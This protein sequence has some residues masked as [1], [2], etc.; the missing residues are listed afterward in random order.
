[1]Y[2]YFFIAK[3]NMRKQRKDM[4]TFFILTCLSSLLIFISSSLLYG[5]PRVIDT[6]HD[7][8]NGADIMILLSDHTPAVTKLSEIIEG[9]IYIDRYEMTDC[10]STYCK[11]RHKGEKEWVEYSFTICA[12]DEKRTIEKTSIDISGLK[13]NEA[14][15]PVSLSTEFSEGS[16]IQLKIG[17]NIYDMKVKG[18]NEDMFYCS[19]VNLGS[20][21][22]FV[23]RGLYND[24]IFE[25]SSSVAQQNKRFALKITNTARKRNMDV[26]EI[27]DMMMNEFVDWDLK[28][29]ASHPEYPGTSFN[30]L[31]APL[32]KTATMIMP[33]I[34]VAIVLLFA[35]II[36]IIAVVII[37]FS[38]KNFIMTNMKNTA[39]MEASGYTVN[40]LVLILLTQLLLI[41][42]IG[43]V[44]GVLTGAALIG[45]IGVIQL[46]LMGLSWNQPVFWGIAAIVVIGI[47]LIITGI[48]FLLGMDYKK[49]S[50]LE[51]LRGGI[52]AHNFKKNHFPF[53]TTG[54]P[55]PL[56]MALKETFGRFSSKIGIIFIAAVLTVSTT[57]GFGL[58]DT[59]FYDD[60]AVMNMGGFIAEDAEVSGDETMYNNL[61]T[62]SSVK[63]VYGDNHMAYEYTRGKSRQSITTRCFTDMENIHGGGLVEGRWPKHDNEVVLATNAAGRLHAEVGDV[64]MIKSGEKEDSYIVCGL[65]QTFNNMGM[66]GFMTEG[67]QERIS[68]K[69]H[70]KTWSIKLKDGFSFKTF[71]SEFKDIYPD[72]DIVNVEEATKST[73]GTIKG[74]MKG[75][76][77]GIAVLT[78]LITAFVEA[79]V[80]RTQINREWRDLGVSKALGFTSSQ[81]IL[82]TTVSNLPGVVIGLILGLMASTASGTKLSI[83]IFGI[84]G[85]KRVD[86]SINPASYLLTF[87]IICGS[88]VITS[89]FTGRRIRGL[90]PVRMITEE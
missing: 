76:S 64:V 2:R 35:L 18:F 58:I 27:S 12:S 11:Y 66:M 61:M 44:S 78:I 22:T 47:C 87:I 89:A 19:S 17:D 83:M 70:E 74:A 39:I 88:A 82:Q 36:F 65:N 68:P 85:F 50:V 40:E 84:F 63:Y 56:T 41:A 20:Y 62:M 54:L 30:F 77:M 60:E 72:V 55:V 73:I 59:F 53:D 26:N 57:T 15:L 43:S 3:N 24:L 46:F 67:G 5:T 71:E 4:F 31:P 79:L 90:D 28:Y 51:A 45:R 69:F 75:I 80:I 42:V 49:T 52:N 86:F 29:V 37:D 38:V 1:M 9:N 16:I 10:I 48:T 6:N 81:L 34:V 21:L 14:V 25:N 33:Y 32:M 13:E 7:L 23:P 8:I